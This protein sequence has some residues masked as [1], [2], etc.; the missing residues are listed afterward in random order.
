MDRKILIKLALEKKPKNQ[1]QL[2]G[3]LL[4]KWAQKFQKIS[5][6]QVQN[7]VK[8]IESYRELKAQTRNNNSTLCVD[9]P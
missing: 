7:R 8:N 5:N 1:L 6:L 3:V 4:K 2:T 9:S